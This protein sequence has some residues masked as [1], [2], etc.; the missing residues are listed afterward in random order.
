MAS[1]DSDGVSKQFFH[2][3]WRKDE[4]SFGVRLWLPDTVVYGFGHPVAWYF[5]SQ[6]GK[7]KRKHKQNLVNA[8]I[9]AA[10]TKR[11]TGSGIV[12]YYVSLPNPEDAAAGSHESYIEYFDREALREFL[13]GRIKED[14]GVLQRFIEPKGPRNAT[15]RAVWTPRI[16][17]LERRTNVRLLHDS[18]FGIFER[19]ITYEGPDHHSTAAPLRGSVLP[20][21]I[22]RICESIVGHVAEVSFQKHRIS[23]MVLN[24]KTDARDRVWLCW[25]SSIRTERGGGAVGRRAAGAAAG[26]VEMGAMVRVPEHV[27]LDT[28]ANHGAPQRRVL[29]RC[30]SCNAKHPEDQFQPVPYK[31]VILHFDRVTA[32]GALDASDRRR[33]VAW[34]PD[35][36]VL[37]A[38]GGVGFGLVKELVREGQSF[39]EEDLAVPPM[40]RHLHRKLSAKMYARLRR[41]P[42]FLHKTCTVCEACFLAFAELASTAPT[43]AARS[44]LLRAGRGRLGA[45]GAPK[46]TLPRAERCSDEAWQPVPVPL[47][48]PLL[49]PAGAK[50]GA[51]TRA[52]TRTEARTARRRRGGE[53]SLAEAARVGNGAADERGSGARPPQLPD[54]VGAAPDLPGTIRDADNARGLA[55]QTLRK[56][57]AEGALGDG[58]RRGVDSCAPSGGAAR[59]APVRSEGPLRGMGASTGNGGEGGGLPLAQAV[60]SQW[61]VRVA[62]AVPGQTAGRR[63]AQRKSPYLTE[64]TAPAPRRRRTL[65]STAPPKAA[66]RADSTRSGTVARGA[67]DSSGGGAAP[68]MSTSAVRHRRFLAD[69]LAKAQAQLAA[70]TAV[71]SLLASASRAGGSQADGVRR[72]RA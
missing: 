6:D 60:Q 12:A 1:I 31:S 65:A 40:L 28:R 37:V 68:T 46:S 32:L 36:R 20:S 55:S 25:S 61:R 13:Y 64:Q 24:F 27:L 17:L 34:P 44:L 42:L 8:R 66:A 35:D 21:R 67:G 72:R 15:I 11:A 45:G 2:Y 43:A 3:L 19:A 59:W 16:C 39:A 70:P 51:K 30:I 38:A 33:S 14:S 9:E 52:K 5:T 26:T 56:R 49:V 29:A 23:R 7:I 62:R 18:R 10:M 54:V 58:N 47:L 41:D 48:L 22:Q 50:A 53:P 69:A 63:G 57:A 71:M 4:L